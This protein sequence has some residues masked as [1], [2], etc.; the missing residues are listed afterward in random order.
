MVYLLLRMVELTVFLELKQLVVTVQD[1]S[2]ALKL[3]KGGGKSVG[4]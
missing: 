3:Q 2:G 1:S 4:M